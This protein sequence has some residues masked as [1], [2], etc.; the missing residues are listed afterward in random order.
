MKRVTALVALLILAA[1]A[2]LFLGGCDMEMDS[3]FLEAIQ[4]RIAEDVEEAGL[5]PTYSVIYDG[6]GNNGGQAPVDSNEYKAGDTA[7][8]LG[9][10]N[11][12]V[13]T[14][15]T[16]VGWNTEADGSGSD[17]LVGDTIA[18]SDAD[19]TLFA[20]WTLKPT[21]TVT[22]HGNGN[23]GGSAPT[24]ATNYEEGQS[25][26][27]KSQGT[28]IFDG[29][30][31]VGWNEASDGSS[32]PHSVDSTFPMPAQNVGLYAQWTTNPTYMVTYYGN[33]SDGGT[34]PIDSNN[35][36]EGDWVTVSAQ[37]SMA[38]EG[39]SFD[40][41][42]TL[43]NG[44]G[45]PRPASSS[46]QMGNANV[47]LYAQWDINSYT[48]S[49]DGNLS[50]GGILPA[51]PTL[52]EYDS[53]VTVLGNTGNLTKS[54]FT[55]GGWNTAAN[56]SGTDYV[57]T[58]TFSMPGS[59]VTLYA[60]WE[61]DVTYNANGSD[62]GSVPTD[63]NTY[64]QGESVTVQGNTGNLVKTQDGIIMRFV[65]WNTQADG[66]GTTYTSGQTFNIGTDNVTLY[67]K[68]SAIRGT[69]PAGGLVFYD[70]GSY[71]DSWRY[72]EAAPESTEWNIYPYPQ[73]GAYGTLIGGTSTGIGAG[74]D[75]TLII[76]SWLNS[77]GE[78]GKAAQLCDA[79]SYGGFTD[80][81]LPSRSEL[82]Y[83]YSNLY[84]N[85]VGGL[86]N[87]YYWSS[88]E[89]SNGNSAWIIS[90]IDGS[91]GASVKTISRVVRAIRA[92]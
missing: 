12:L 25:V 7:T 24:D 35:Y 72:L 30:T 19:V 33:G 47:A 67:A 71:S 44:F 62:S 56:G 66:N 43:A 18:I 8:V 81:F 75:N 2:I 38:R 15:Y 36:E 34:V 4:E 82:A 49:Y 29:A 37:G 40:D 52:Y 16:F 9:N 50:T 55:F 83:M 23:T 27:V 73:W 45:T 91:N 74:A 90:F 65:G 61:Y 86:K 13:K 54:D 1:G 68:F 39:H 26:T 92:F 21:Y 3:A 51:V 28:L 32:T 89:Y 63:G 87:N 48:L 84:Q 11:G 10:T 41:W 17:Y 22:Y 79:L 20:R 78:S 42:N 53:T 69:G 31:F 14:A 5:I 58:N 76:V 57:A 88:S 64:R 46:F 60:I 70:K 85:G 77:N 6:N 59:N 80:W